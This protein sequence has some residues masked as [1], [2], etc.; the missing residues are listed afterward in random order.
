MHAICER[1]R[2]TGHLKML[3]GGGGQGSGGGGGRERG[4]L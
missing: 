1:G 3:G 4:I 2:A